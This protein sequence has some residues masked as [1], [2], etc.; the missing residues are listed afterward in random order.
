MPLTPE[1]TYT[2]QKATGHT[3][4]LAGPGS[5]KTHTII[6]KIFYIFEK[7]IIPEP[8]GLLVITFTNAAANEIRSRLRSKGFQQLSRVWIGTF[9]SF[10]S[11]LL[12]CY[13]SDI[14][15]QENFE[16]LEKEAQD[17]IINHVISK[18]LKGVSANNFKS[19]LEA[20]KR[21][22]IY[23]GRNDENLDS[24]L[25]LAY[26]V[27]QKE[28]TQRNTLDFGD[29]VALSVRLLQE[30]VLASRLFK[31]FFRYVIAD[32]FQDSDL[33]QLEIIY[34][35]AK[36]AV[37]STIVADD[38][39]SIYRFRGAVRENVVKIKEL[40]NAEKIILGT[41]FRSDQIIVDAARAIIGFEINR[42]PKEIRAASKNT[43]SLYK[44]EFPTQNAEAVQIAQW[45]AKLAT[46]KRVE[47]LGEI[48][49]ITRNRARANR[50][51]AELDKVEILW[52]DRSRLNFQDSWEI[53]L[54]LAILALSCD[55][56][57]SVKLRKVLDAIEDEGIS[58]RLGYKDAIDI[59][60]E[61]R[62]C[63]L[64]KLDFYPSPENIEAICE[65]VQLETLVQS[66]CWSST[67]A[68]RLLNN[69]YKMFNDLK[70]EAQLLG[71]NLLDTINRLAGYSAV[72]IM[73]GHASKGRE[74]D[75]VFLAGL[76]DDVLPFYKTHNNEEELAEER[77]IFYVSVTRAR[78]AVYLTSAAKTTGSWK[79]QPSRFIK[80]I[81]EELFSPSPE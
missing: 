49:V 55:L 21:K 16:L 34:L 52:F 77:R 27:Y 65:I 26:K 6:E 71:L 74:F 56:N 72:Q 10:G 57:S 35:L 60:I 64:E 42:T 39:Q 41:N 32:E 61:I 70:Q 15:V 81:P 4:V 44:I 54:S 19:E 8:H 63:L 50:I 68:N 37:G 43:G 11:Y 30:S 25:R 59:A 48:A 80:H 20:L 76:E 67:D 46:Q 33:Q 40:L 75:Y 69:L 17:Q 31:N 9:H 24:K 7:N 23:P 73:S 14:G 1:Q 13:G 2:V 18:Y 58:N 5:G 66:V 28:L 47:T 78:K 45:V 38:D 22:G 3:V 29:L 62:N 51:L 53:S 12:S 79:R 36:D